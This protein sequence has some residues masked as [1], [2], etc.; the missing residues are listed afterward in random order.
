MQNTIYTVPHKFRK[1]YHNFTKNSTIFTFFHILQVPQRMYRHFALILPVLLCSLFVC[2]KAV[3][4]FRC[5]PFFCSPA[6]KSKKCGPGF[7][8]VRFVLFMHSLQKE[9]L[10]GILAWVLPD[11]EAVVPSKF[12]NAA[13]IFK[14]YSSVLLYSRRGR[15]DEDA[16]RLEPVETTTLYHVS[17]A[18]FLSV[19]STSSMV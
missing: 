18:K 14:P 1:V 7:R 9:A 11:Q 3:L 8:Q 15:K 12:R 5:P 6:Q 17:T 4:P 10:F 13:E 16:G 19:T 2:F